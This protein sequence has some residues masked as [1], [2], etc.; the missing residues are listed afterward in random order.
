MTLAVE[1]MVVAG[2]REVELLK[3]KWTVV[4][5]DRQPAAHFEHT[6]AVTEAGV[7]I[8]SDGRAP[9]LL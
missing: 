6:V 1:P 7:D 2:R 5:E 4:T 3:D 8:L 9:I